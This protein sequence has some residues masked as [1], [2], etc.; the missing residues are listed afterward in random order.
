MAQSGEG[1]LRGRERRNYGRKREREKKEKR[2][3]MEE[4]DEWQLW[5]NVGPIFPP[6]FFPNCG[7]KMM[8]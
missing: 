5:K 3:R 4:R 6:F 7:N 1:E 2:E 8:S